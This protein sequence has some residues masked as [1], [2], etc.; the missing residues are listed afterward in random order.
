MRTIVSWIEYIY[1]CVCVIADHRAVELC[2]DV[3]HRVDS[4]ICRIFETSPCRGGAAEI[5]YC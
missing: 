1:V 5:F 3:S 2:V 4:F